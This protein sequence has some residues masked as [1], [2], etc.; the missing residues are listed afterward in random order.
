MASFVSYILVVLAVL[1]A[2]PVAMFLLEIVAALLLP[3][4]KAASHSK[5]NIQQRI[6][7]LVPAHNE[8]TGILPTLVDIKAQLLSGDRM[9]VIADNC[10][11]DTAAVS[12]SAGAE[13]IERN[14]LTKI[15]KGFALDF[16]LKHLDLDPPEFVIIV[17]ADCRVAEGA[18]DRL[19]TTC[20]ISH[21][22]VQAL[23]LMTAPDDSPINYSVA[24][25]AW[26]IKNWVRPLGL[27]ALNL[28][29]Q[30]MGT[31]MAFPWEVIRSA[32]LAS[33]SIVEDLK[34]GL[35][36]AQ[37]ESP[38]LFCPSASVTSHFPLSVEGAKS[39]RKRWEEGHIRMILTTAP[40][41][42][43]RAVVR[44]D[45][46][47]FT[48]ALDL[49]IPPLSL[50]VILLAGMVSIA[51]LAVLLGF[52]SAALVISATSFTATVASVFSIWLKY[53]RDVLP[54]S[55]MLSIASHV[56]EKFPLYR[57]LFSANAASR[58]NRTDRKKSE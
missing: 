51:G 53:G 37:T 15:G 25:F 39:Q 24:E 26:R 18:I 40:R 56:F 10:C 20:A 46:N 48:L 32:N 7:V 19:V 21:R 30:L 27:Y 54:P 16:G 6:V 49:A 41:F 31:G 9:L 55:A 35:D 50:L 3:A 34:L 1:L 29:C 45:L 8:S 12:A 22:P 58:W 42:I 36:L 5:N 28:P 2:I 43:Y 17:D 11:D 52:S 57:H 4:R 44:K 23:D 14:D 13:V 33:G 47:L 38:P